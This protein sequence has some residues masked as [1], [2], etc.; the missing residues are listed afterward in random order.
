M[1][2]HSKFIQSESEFQIEN[3]RIIEGASLGANVVAK[4]NKTT[5]NLEVTNINETYDTLTDIGWHVNDDGQRWWSD[6]SNQAF[7]TENTG[8]SGNW[9]IYKQ[10]YIWT[11]ARK[12]AGKDS[13]YGLHIWRE[14]NSEYA[15]TWGG[16][17]LYP[18]TSAKQ[19]GH[20]YRLSFDY[21]GYSGGDWFDVYQNYEIGWGSMGIDLPGAW[22]ASIAPFDTD[23]QWQRYEHEY[24]IDD[25]LLNYVPGTDW[26]N[27]EP[28]NAWHPDTQYGTGWFYVTYNGYVYRHRSGRPA[29]TRGVTPEDEYNATGSSSGPWDWKIPMNP[30]YLDIYR[31]IKLGFNYQA[32][33]QRGS[34]VFIDNIQLTD[35]TNNKRWKFNGSGWEADNISDATL[36]VKAVGCAYNAVFQGGDTNNPDI[37]EVHGNRILEING[38]RIYDTTGRGLRFTKFNSSG[39]VIEDTLYDTYGNDAHRQELADQLANMGGS[40]YWTLTSYDA[41][42]NANG[43]TPLHTQLVNMGSKMW[44]INESNYFVGYY[45]STYAAV[46]LGNKIIKEDGA[47]HD[48]RVYKR[49]AVIDL[50]L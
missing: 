16:L 32:Q 10:S 47:R 1:A 38:S 49:K 2:T 50:K 7:T 28:Q 42:S 33:N 24:T 30:G 40:E 14:P 8:G 21:R 27:G 15:S 35:V 9:A 18:P 3:G 43:G 19:S 20:T 5:G 44:D 34:H 41:I 12:Y 45:R 25:R 36:H 31:Q 26:S 17:R 11:T 6:P 37:F 4:M 48:D 22:G 46:G 39:T 23:W 13:L 29:P